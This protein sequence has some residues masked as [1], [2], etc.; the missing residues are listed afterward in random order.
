MR[1]YCGGEEKRREVVY[2][3][4]VKESY[5]HEIAAS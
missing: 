1:F 5:W 3:P 4:F 2:R